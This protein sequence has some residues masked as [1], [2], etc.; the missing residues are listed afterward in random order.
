[1]ADNSIFVLFQLDNNQIAVDV[2]RVAFPALEA[3]ELL[4]RPG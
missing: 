1:M 4:F 2:V 3:A